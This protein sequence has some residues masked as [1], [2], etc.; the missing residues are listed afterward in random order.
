MPSL[1]K[2]VEEIIQNGNLVDHPFFN[3][4][5][6]A[7]EINKID[8]SNKYPQFRACLERL[9]DH[10][11][12]QGCLAIL[13]LTP[14]LAADADQ[15]HRI[16]RAGCD[17]E[18][19]SCALLAQGDYS[20][21]Y[22]SRRRFGNRNYNVWRDLVIPSR[23][24]ADFEKTQDV[25]Q[26]LLDIFKVDPNLTVS[27]YIRSWLIEYESNPFKEKDWRYYYIKYA[28]FRKHDK[29]FYYWPDALKVYESFMILSIEL[30]G[31]NL[32]PILLAIKNRISSNLFLGNYGSPLVY[33][34]GLATI[35][36]LNKDEGFLLE[37]VDPDGQ[38]LIDAAVSRGYATANAICPIQKSV[39]GLD[40]QDR[41]DIGA[42]LIRV[43]NDLHINE[44]E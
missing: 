14:D 2:S 39:N 31:K 30:S 28:E 25:L 32:D 19:I 5:Q 7:E 33:S 22:G 6:L 9:E 41:V 12:L 36:I 15:F 21:Q 1:L 20:Q 3:S 16:F 43:L 35:R 27:K 13:R 42:N 8:F 40:I 4:V 26:K 37:A 10:Q 24:K 18:Q 38:L 34:H 17:Y 23:R 11:L 44:S 29:G